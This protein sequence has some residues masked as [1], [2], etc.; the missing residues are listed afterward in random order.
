MKTTLFCLI[1]SLLSVHTF[2]TTSTITHSTTFKKTR[3]GLQYHLNNSHTEQK[4][5]KA[6]K[7]QT[8]KIHYEG[9]LDNGTIFDSSIAKDEPVILKTTHLIK[10]LQEGIKLMKVGQ[11]ATFIIPADLAYGS[12]GSGSA[13]P[14]NSP[15]IFNIE[16]LEIID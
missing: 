6:K 16:L 8:V 13:I 15:V 5:P 12:L 9:K 2:A 10:G 11:K 7:A 14:A 1:L 3:S 4:T